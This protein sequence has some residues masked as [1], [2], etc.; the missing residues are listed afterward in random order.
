MQFSRNSIYR[1][2][3]F[4]ASRRCLDATSAT[5]YHYGEANVWVKT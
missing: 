2:L 5:P 4:R 1:M 3:M